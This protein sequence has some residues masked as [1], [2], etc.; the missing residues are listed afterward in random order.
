MTMNLNTDIKSY[1]YI[2]TSISDQGVL[3]YWHDC[4]ILR[5]CEFKDEFY[6]GLSKEEQEV[7]GSFHNFL[8]EIE[9]EE[10]KSFADNCHKELA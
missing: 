4:D 1:T 7:F 10:L 8:E 5:S 6:E 9:F 3:M 2:A